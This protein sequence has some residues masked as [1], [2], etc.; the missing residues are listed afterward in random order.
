MDP[1]I[2]EELVEGD[3]GHLPAYRVE[4]AQDHRFGG[5]IDDQVNPQS[6]LQRPNVAPFPANDPAL[7]LVIR[8]RDDR[9]RGFPGLV[10]G[11][12]LDG[13]YQHLP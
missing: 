12:A 8:Q 1:T 13:S 10:G 2:A 6:R 3:P 11:M 9:Y 5:V 7:D 4:A